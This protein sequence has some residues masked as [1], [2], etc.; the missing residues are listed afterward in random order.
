MQMEPVAPPTTPAVQQST[1]TY[2]YS[3]YK[4]YGPIIVNTGRLSA[5]NLRLVN[6]I[7]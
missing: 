6:V 3:H 5:Y 2:N 7:T 4:P 1:S